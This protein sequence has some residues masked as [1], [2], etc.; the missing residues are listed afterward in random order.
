MSEEVVKGKGGRRKEG[1][2]ENADGIKRIKRI[3]K[4]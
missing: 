1:N 3:N 4:R 2:G